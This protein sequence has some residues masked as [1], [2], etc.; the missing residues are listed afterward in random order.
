MA[1]IDEI[2][3]E[4]QRQIDAERWTQEHDDDHDNG[5][6]A[7][8]ACVYAHY[9]ATDHAHNQAIECF[10]EEDCEDFSPRGWPWAPEAFKPKP[11]R[12]DLIR[13]AALIVAEIERHDRSKGSD[14]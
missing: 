5:K 3:T 2:A 6:M 13:A 8:S 14:R 9:A 1:V 12:Y 4:R 10:T 7:L 11:R